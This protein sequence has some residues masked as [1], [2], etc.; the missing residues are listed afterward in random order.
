MTNAETGALDAPAEEHRPPGEVLIVTGMSGAGR[1][2]AADALEDLG[3]YVVDNLPPQMLRPLLELTELAAGAL[4]RVAVVVDVRG[5]DLFVALPEITRA[6]RDGR[7]VRVMFLDASDDVLVRRFEA[8]RRPHPL[9]GDGTVLDG[10]RLER[11]RLAAVRE[12]ADVIIDTSGFNIHQLATQVIDLFSA[13]GAARHSVT[14]MS[15]GFKYGMP[16]DADLVAD[17]RFLPNPFWNDDLRALTGESDEVRDF[18]L[19]QEGAAEFIDAYTAALQP[20]LAGYQRENKGH[21]VI[22]VGCTGGKHRSV[23]VAK[24]LAARLSSVPGVA[25]RVKHRDLGRE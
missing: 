15:F 6:L 9:Q 8:V 2:T 10:I 11:D 17:M 21:S 23:A 1:S 14:I 16:P 19:T 12:S 25:V 22:A 4:P 18:V 7:P 13:E 3:W 20:V 24:E 5:R